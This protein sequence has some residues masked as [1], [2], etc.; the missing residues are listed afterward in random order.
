MTKDTWYSECWIG[1]FQEINAYIKNEETQ[2]NGLI[3]CFR[4]LDIGG[5]KK[6]KSDGKE[7]EW[8]KNS[9]TK[10]IKHSPVKENKDIGNKSKHIWSIMF[11]QGQ[12]ASSIEKG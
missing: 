9:Q 10:S 11:W 1:K 4:E 12:Q 5:K 2:T 8:R 6:I 7:I 3:L